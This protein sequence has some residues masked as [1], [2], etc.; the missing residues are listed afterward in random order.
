MGDCDETIILKSKKS[1]FWDESEVIEYDDNDMTNHY[2]KEMAD[3]NLWIK[4][5]ELN[6]SFHPSKQVH[7][8]VFLYRLLIDFFYLEEVEDVD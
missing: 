3:I 4:E 7:E 8:K 5:A 2:R 1:S 6:C